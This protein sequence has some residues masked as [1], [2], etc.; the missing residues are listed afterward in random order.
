MAQEQAG[1][2]ETDL[3]PEVGE[4]SGLMQL[5]QPGQEQTAEESAQHTHRQKEGRTGGYSA[6]P[7]E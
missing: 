3:A 7:V 6:L 4:P 5:D 1:V 2:G